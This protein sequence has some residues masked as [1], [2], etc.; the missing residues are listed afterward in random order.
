M[1]WTHK[2][3]KRAASK[4]ERVAQRK[5]LPDRLEDDYPI[6]EELA[7]EQANCCPE[8]PCRFCLAR[9]LNEGML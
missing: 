7:E 2:P 8:K 4:A 3:E 1:S 5:L 6:E 9:S